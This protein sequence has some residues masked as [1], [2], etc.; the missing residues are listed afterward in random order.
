MFATGARRTEKHMQDRP[1][2]A[3]Y[4]QRV[5]FFFPRP[6]ATT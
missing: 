4:Q 2:Y 1:G 5:P 3:D 6:L